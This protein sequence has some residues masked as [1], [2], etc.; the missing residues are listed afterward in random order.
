MV[1]L[2]HSHR[3]LWLS[4]AAALVPPFPGLAAR[5]V[6]FCRQ[7]SARGRQAGMPK[8]SVKK[9]AKTGGTMDSACTLHV[10]EFSGGPAKQ[11]YSTYSGSNLAVGLCFTDRCENPVDPCARAV[12][13]IEIRGAQRHRCR[14][15]V[16]VLRR[17]CTPQHTHPNG[18]CWCW[19]TT[20]LGRGCSDGV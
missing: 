6:G 16:H 5:A 3:R 15:C 20:H 9:G 19:L 11:A 7:Q 10:F 17:P 8:L 14:C 4:H 1:K 12:V 13:P 18:C 2:L